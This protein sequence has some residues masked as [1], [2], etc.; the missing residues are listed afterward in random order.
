M[1]KSW[2]CWHLT[3]WRG[4]LFNW[5]ISIPYLFNVT[6][7]T[8]F[9]TPTTYWNLLSLTGKGMGSTVRELKQMQ[10]VYDDIKMKH[11]KGMFCYFSLIVISLVDGQILLHISQTELELCEILLI[12]KS[13]FCLL[14][15]L[16]CWE[17]VSLVFFFPTYAIILILRY[18][19]HFYYLAFQHKLLVLLAIS[20][21]QFISN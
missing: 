14:N 15:V 19:N 11:K 16:C 13:K 7:C 18:R 21:M 1:E 2:L 20:F 10:S 17:E 12:F 8:P 6:F 4:I 5:C 3:R 9:S